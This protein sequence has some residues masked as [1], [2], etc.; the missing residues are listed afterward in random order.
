M[1]REGT[2]AS[3]RF[4]S[5]DAD[6]H[7]LEPRDTWIEYIDPEYRDRAIRIEIDSQGD[8]VLLV[9]GRPVESMRN[10]LAALGGI[11]LDPAEALDRVTGRLR[12]EDGCPPGGYDAAARLDVMDDEGIDIALLY[13]TIG[14]C[15]E[16]HVTDPALAT[17]YARAYNRYIVDFCSH[18]LRRLV[19][20][21]HI[22]L[23]D[24]DGAVAEVRRAREAGCR[25]VY[26]SPDLPARGDRGLSDSAFDRFWSTCEDL[27]MPIGFHVI[28]RDAPS[29]RPPKMDRAGGHALFGFAFLAIDVMAAFTEMLASGVF[30][31]HPR[32]RCTVLESGATWIAAWLDRMDHKFEVMRTI[33]PTT[34]KPS[35]YFY[36]QCVVSADPD[37]TVIAPI[38]DTVGADYFVWASDYPHIDASFGVVGEIRSRL[39]PLADEQ[40]AKVLGLNAQRFYGL[41]VPA[42]V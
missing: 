19:P 42:G 3:G 30:E 29:Y 1:T 40:Q 13:P 27:D 10:G 21:A 11:N 36:R 7:V 6:G 18:D 39:E 2:L 31:K 4:L 26:L 12:Y 25:A 23:I 28:V 8:E 38:I 32:L 22:S 41:E 17:A 33:T 20:V 37:E 34:M 14:I 5:V 9:D 16:G 24:E 15:W 35:E